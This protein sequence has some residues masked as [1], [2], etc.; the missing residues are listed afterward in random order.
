M[1]FNRDHPLSTCSD[2]AGPY[3]CCAGG[4]HAQGST[5]R[6]QALRSRLAVAESVLEGHRQPIFR[7]TFPELSCDSLR[8][9]SFHQ[10]K[11]VFY[12]TTFP[13]VT[14]CLNFRLMFISVRIYKPGAMLAQ[15][16]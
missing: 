11:R 6:V 13:W 5:T 12:A 4:R 2:Y 7:K 16:L 8:L 14:D 10:D 1:L 3:E 9:P 15:C